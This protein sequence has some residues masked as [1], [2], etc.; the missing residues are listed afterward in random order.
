[1]TCTT[2]TGYSLQNA[3]ITIN[4]TTALT[5][6]L[7]RITSHY[8]IFTVTITNISWE[9]NSAIFQCHVGKLVSNLLIIHGK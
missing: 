5:E 4:E 3:Y 1:M 8:Y 6:D 2:S 9:Y 7:G